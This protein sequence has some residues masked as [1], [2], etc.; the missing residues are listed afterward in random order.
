MKVLV[1]GAGR[2]G[3][4]RVEDL[5]GDDRVTDVVVTNRNGDRARTL[6]DQFGATTAP[7]GADV[8]ADAVVVAVGTDAHEAV[9]RQV[10]PLGIPVLCEKPVAMTLQGT[11]AA[12]S[13]AERSGSRLQIGFQRRFDPAIRG[14]YDTITD[15]ALG[16][17]YSLTMTSHDHTPSPREFIEGSGGIF[18][19]LHVHDF[20]IA[21]WLTGE[22][23]DT[24]YATGSVRH[25]T[26]YADFNDFDVSSIA[27]VTTS[28]IHVLITGARHDPRGHDVRLEA[29]GSHDSVTAGLNRRTPLNALEDDLSFSDDPYRGFVD[30]FRDA[31]RA[32]TRA[33]VSFALGE[34]ENPCPPDAAVESLRVAVACEQSIAEGRRIRISD[35][36]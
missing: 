13:L 16:T 19:D 34:I 33:F 25:N 14:V 21:R 24:V 20:D 35:V 10:L 8:D 18:R 26:D 5:A 4:I 6:A 12:I 22:D 1:I 27:A 15:G 9:L 23:I 3:A 30:R 28:G 29:F 32:E 2:M 7:W 11:E 17:L 31:F 36:H